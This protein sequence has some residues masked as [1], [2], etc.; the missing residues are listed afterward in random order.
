VLV[1]SVAYGGSVSDQLDPFGFE[2]PA[3]ERVKVTVVVICEAQDPGAAGRCAG[4][5]DGELRWWKGNIHTHSLWSDGDDF[6]EAVAE[7][8]ERTGQDDLSSFY[9]L[10]AHHWGRAEV[11]DKAIEYRGLSGEQVLRP[12][13][14]KPMFNFLRR[15][16]ARKLLK[17][18]WCR[19]GCAPGMGVGARAR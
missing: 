10:L 13:E 3:E 17:N 6:P 8:Y 1:S 18:T 2:D 16:K 9:P 14:G 4:Q 5:P 12:D 7:W 19:I 11:D 15:R